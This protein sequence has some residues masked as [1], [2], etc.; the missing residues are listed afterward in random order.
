[1]TTKRIDILFVILILSIL[2]T[3]CGDA[4]RLTN[5]VVSAASDSVTIQTVR[6]SPRLSTCD[7]SAKQNLLN[8]VDSEITPSSG[9]V[10]GMTL[11]QWLDAKMSR[12]SCIAPLSE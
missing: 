3:A 7:F 5:L 6:S 10:E 11:D 1:M 9:K 2:L 12:F 4:P 8:T